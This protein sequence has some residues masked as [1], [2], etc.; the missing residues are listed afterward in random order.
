MA[1]PVYYIAPEVGP[2]IARIV[3]EMVGDDPRL[4]CPE[5][6][7]AAADYNYRDNPS[8]AAA[9]QTGERGAYWDVLRRTLNSER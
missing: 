1:L 9:I 4:L 2:D 7:V 6:D 8:L 3:N 5:A